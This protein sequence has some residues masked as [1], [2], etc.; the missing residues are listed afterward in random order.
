MYPE[1]AERIGGGRL[2]D[3]NLAHIEPGK[4]A[5]DEG[6]RAEVWDFMED[7]AGDVR[8]MTLY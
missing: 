6:H 1:E 8:M 7:A 4:W 2:L 3:K 5:Q